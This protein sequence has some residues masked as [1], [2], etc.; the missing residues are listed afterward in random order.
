MT[1][2]FLGIIS[3]NPDLQP[4][5]A[6]TLGIGII[7][8]PSYLPKFRMSVDY[9]DI[10]ISDAI[11]SVSVQEIV[12]RCF[13]GNQSFC[14]AITR[15]IGPTG[16][17]EITE[18]RRSPFN[19][20]TLNAEG[21]DIA[22]NYE[23]IETLGGD[24]SF[25]M[26][27]THYLTDKSDDGIT[28]PS[29]SVGENAGGDP[30]DWIA[31]LSATFDKGPLTTTLTA[32]AISDGV[33]DNNYIVCSANC[34]ASSTI[35]R[36]VNKNDIDGV[37]FLDWSAGY[38]FEVGEAR[39]QAYFVIRNVLNEYPPTVHN[40]PGGVSHQLIATNP[41]LYDLLGTVFLAGIRVEF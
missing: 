13:E 39:A 11:G 32:R 1:V 17:L 33:Y 37:V 28:P 24:L 16:I 25:A 15:G 38:N 41:N 5:E 36:T 34:P 40:G 12:N 6:D 2:Q 7:F 27:A 29:N 18:V 19:F 21:I 4:E 31:R 3:G 8:E 23:S 10:E 30:P 22:A 35:N 20:V 26:V 9:Y 14:D